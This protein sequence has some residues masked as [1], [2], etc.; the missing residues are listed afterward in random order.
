[1]V[2]VTPTKKGHGGA[3]KP[4]SKHTGGKG[5]K[6]VKGENFYRDAKQ[7]KRV[8]LLSKNGIA[9]KPIRD[10]AGNVTQAQ[11]FQSSDATPGRVQPDRRWFGNTRVISQDALDHFR[12]ALGSRVDDPYSVL[13]RRNKLPMSLLQDAKNGKA[14]RL[15]AVESFEETFGPNSKRKR[16]RLDPGNSGSFAELAQASEKA[17]LEAEEKEELQ[18]F[19]AGGHHLVQDGAEI[20]MA[21]SSQ[22]SPT[23]LVGESAGASGSRVIDPTSLQ[24]EPYSMTVTRGRSE[25]IYSKGQSRRI[26]AELYKVIDSSD[27][28]IHV[29]DVRDPMGT[30]C[31]SVIKHIKEEKPHKHLVFLLNKVDLV[32][33]WVTARWVK[34]LSKEYPTLAFHASI[35]NSFGKG[36]LIQLL[37]Q[38]SQLHSDRK[39]ISIG[40]IGYPNV[41]KSSIINTLKKKKVCNVAP[42]P[43]ETKVWQYV[44]LTRRIYLVDCPGIVPVGAADSETNTVLKGVVRVENL[45]TPAEH[46]QALL[47][48]VKPDYLRRTYGLEQWSNHEDFLAQLA[49]KMGKLLKGGDAD[50]ETAAKMVLNDWIRG[51]IPFFVAPPLPAFKEKK[52]ALTTLGAPAETAASK[53]QDGEDVG[54]VA[55]KKIIKG[56]DQPIRAIAVVNKFSKAD[57]QGG[58]PEDFEPDHDAEV[59]PGMDEDGAEED[60][61]SGDSEDDG[62]EEQEDEDDDETLEGLKWEDVFG[63]TS[64]MDSRSAFAEEDGEAALAPSEG[65]SDSDVSRSYSGS[66]AEFHSLAGTSNTS[67]PVISSIVA[68]KR[69]AS[70]DLDEEVDNSKKS[71]RAA[72]AKAKE[73]R[74]KTSKQKTENFY[75]HANVKN[76]NRK[77]ASGSEDASASAGPKKKERGSR[78]GANGRMARTTKAKI[79]RKKK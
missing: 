1:M 21:Q 56:V 76:K 73:A 11:E 8:K 49:K 78:V 38:F 13:L 77:K 37:R 28:V 17:G 54:L 74:V 46:I 4:G 75:T 34:V 64:G 29:L 30:K 71:R 44:T 32:P 12:T 48:R 35:N 2:K 72:E 61:A 16:P 60:I 7:A 58:L 20:G 68:G 31:K 67:A 69:K 18:K 63:G 79:A 62:E 66:E 15:T 51:K 14:P 25:P 43:G 36:A 59:A 39:Q 47:T 5:V 41:G 45:E 33:T 22:A 53:A 40:M 65:G 70:D 55:K 24:E 3:T 52:P 57:A 10:A 6:F 42:I 9:S 27:V 26:W 23:G 50:L 19:K